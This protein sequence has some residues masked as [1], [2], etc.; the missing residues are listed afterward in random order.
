M[1]RV[2]IPPLL[3]SHTNG[4]QVAEVGG[5]TLAEVL[6]QLDEQFPG[7]R[8]QL[9]DSEGLRPG[10]AVDIGGS[11]ASLGLLAKTEPDDE[12]HFLPYVGGG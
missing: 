9:C 12:I 8:A 5:N 10:L 4:E 11:I 1:P 6:D 3:R 2:F 7:I